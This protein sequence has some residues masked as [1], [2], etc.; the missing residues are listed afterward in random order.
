VQTPEGLRYTE[1]HEWV[2]VEGEVA[3]VGITDYA[4]EALG[5]IVFVERPPVG[6][7][8]AKGEEIATI[9][10]VKAA[11]PIYSPVSGTVTQTNAELQGQPELVNKD[12]YGAYILVLK[13]ED[14]GELATLLDAAG[15]RQAVERDKKKH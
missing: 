4:Q 8:Y 10:S 7:S 12:A 9:E 14:P 15:Y 6:E 11:S 3:Y 2:R 1:T 13:L 5:D